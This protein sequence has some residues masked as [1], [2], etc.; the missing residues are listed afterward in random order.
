M[1]GTLEPRREWSNVPMVKTAS[2]HY[3]AARRAFEKARQALSDARYA[4][5]HNLGAEHV[6]LGVKFARIFNQQGVDH[7][8]QAAFATKLAAFD[9]RQRANAW[10]CD[11]GTAA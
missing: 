1:T 3:K 11:I 4:K 7:R 5:R 9:K 2:G 8:R 10:M 6:R